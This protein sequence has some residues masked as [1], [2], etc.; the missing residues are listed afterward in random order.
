MAAAAADLRGTVAN[1][2]TKAPIAGALIRATTEGIDLQ[3]TTDAAGDFVIILPD[4][5]PAGLHIQASAP[6]FQSLDVDVTDPSNLPFLPLR[7]QP[8]FTAEVEVTGLRAV[9]GETPVTVTNVGR[10]EVEQRYWA[11]D[12]PIFLSPV[13]GFY[14]YNDSGNGIGY[15]YFFLRSFDMRRTAVSLNGVP[16]NDAH[17]HGLFFID[18]ADFL[19][20]TDTIQV[21][22]GVGTNL[23]GGSAIGGSIDVQTSQPAAEHRLRLVT[24][25]GSYGTSRLSLSYDT[26]LMDDR[27]AATFRYSK[28]SSDGY[29]DQSWASM[30]NYYFSLVRYGQKTTLKV[31]LF[32]GP[33]DT[34][35]AYEG[36]S[37][38][39]LDGDVT[40]NQLNDRRYNPL[41]YETRSI[42]F[43]QPHY[44]VIHNWQ[45]DEDLVLQNTF[46]FFSGDGYF[47]QYK[48]N[49]WFPEYGLEP[50][51]PRGA[52]SSKP[53]IWFAAVRST[54]GTA[55]GSPNLEWR[56]GRGRGLLQVGAAVRLHSGRH[57]G[58]VAVGAVLPSG[59]GS[60]PPLLRLPAR[61]NN[62]AALRP[63]EL[64]VQR[65][66]E[67]ARRSHL[68]FAALR[69][70]P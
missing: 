2:N 56:H 34:H 60:R 43:F 39:Y 13:P 10:K 63:G 32:G 42:S 65:P 25:G 20:T 33:E 7:L 48:S 36:I 51:P 24:L 55:A 47:Q 58:T 64:E 38:A 69:H 53:P 70:A 40:G 50:F 19:A 31:N 1:A 23:Y 49:A 9:A 8:H 52:R 28:V 59:P 44:Q 4:P 29:R 68:D 21:Q 61:Q 54:S 16:I 5:P 18:L 62:P 67:P 27:W 30:W 15:S 46:F 57:F 26:G 35:L 6:G 14:A 3:T 22:R 66:V 11:Q 41:E 12:V 17:S 45:I 37:K